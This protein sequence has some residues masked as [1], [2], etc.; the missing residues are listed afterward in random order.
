M[1]ED[2]KKMGKGELALAYLKQKTRL[3]TDRAK[4]K[5]MQQR[6][7]DAGLSALGALAGAVIP[8]YLIASNPDREFLDENRTIETEAVLAAA[9]VLGGV[10][11]Y[12]TDIDYATPI[13]VTGVAV[14]AS[15]LG[16][17]ARQRAQQ[18]IGA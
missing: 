15:Y 9:G 12:V 13:M 1:A 2:V 18:N 10:A 14:G 11:A 3:L 7:Q 4:N 8:A 16:K 6:V 5:E 17:V